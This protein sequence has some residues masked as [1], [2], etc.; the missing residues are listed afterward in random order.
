M[1]CG[2]GEWES[3]T[4]IVHDRMGMLDDDIEDSGE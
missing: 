2:A 1:D 3:I 4:S